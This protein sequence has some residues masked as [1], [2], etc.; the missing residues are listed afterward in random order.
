MWIMGL[1]G[2]RTAKC[3]RDRVDYMYDRC[4]RRVGES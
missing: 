4:N 2:L 1:K 3:R